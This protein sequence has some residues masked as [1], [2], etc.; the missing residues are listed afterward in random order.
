[1]ILNCNVTREDILRAEE[2]F[3]PNL[4]SVKGKTTR[5]PTEH[6][7]LTLK[8][9]PEDILEKYGDVTLAIDVMAINKIPFIITISRHIHFGTAKL[10]CN[11]SKRTIMTSIQQVMR[12]YHARGFRVCNILGDGGF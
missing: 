3:G 2:F 1:M 8:K 10:I 11:K 4:G 12:A 6:A 7:S 9:V 5:K